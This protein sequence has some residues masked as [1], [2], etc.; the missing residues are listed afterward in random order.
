M[1]NSWSTISKYL[2]NIYNVDIICERKQTYCVE[3]SGYEKAKN[4]RLMH[5]CTCASCGITKTKLVKQ[6]N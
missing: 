2:I 6:G 1:K 5:F 3:P 4:G